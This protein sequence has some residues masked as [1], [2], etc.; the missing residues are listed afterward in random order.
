MHVQDRIQLALRNPLDTEKVDPEA[1]ERLLGE[2]Q[3]AVNE[4]WQK[5]EQLAGMMQ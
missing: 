4:R 1:A 3:K 5:Y 2:A